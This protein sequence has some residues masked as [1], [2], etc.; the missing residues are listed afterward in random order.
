MLLLCARAA[1]G[2][3][4]GWLGT[5]RSDGCVL[6][7]PSLLAFVERHGVLDAARPSPTL[8]YPGRLLVVV[9]SE[10]ADRPD[11]CT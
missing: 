5:P 7:P 4:I 10:R 6:L 1:D 3:S 9:D 8:P 2:G 11:W